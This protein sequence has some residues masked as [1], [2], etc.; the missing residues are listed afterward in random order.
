MQSKSK[1]NSLSSNE[2]VK[3]NS[4]DLAYNSKTKMRDGAQKKDVFEEGVK[5]YSI[6]L[7]WVNKDKKLDQTFIHNAATKEKLYTA[8]LEP[9]V[10]WKKANPEADV[11]IWYDAKLYSPEA[12]VRTK[13]ALEESIKKP[14]NFFKSFFLKK[15][16]KKALEEKGESSEIKFKDINDIPIVK[17]NR[18][19]FNEKIPLYFRIDLLKLVICLHSLTIESKD[20]AIFADLETGNLRTDENQIVTGA[21]LNKE[22]L[23]DEKSMNDLKQYGIITNVKMKVI[24]ENQFLQVINNEYIVEALRVNVNVCL[25]VI[26]NTLNMDLYKN[27]AGNQ[28]S[29]MSDVYNVPFHSTIRDVTRYYQSVQI[30]GGIKVRADIVGKGSEN[31]WVKYDP[32]D[33]GYNILGVLPVCAGG[34]LLFLDFSANLD[35]TKNI[36]LEV[37]KK[38]ISYPISPSKLNDCAIRETYTR[39]GNEH[40]DEVTLPE[41]GHKP[42]VAKF[43]KNNIEALKSIGYKPEKDELSEDEIF[44]AK[45]S[46]DFST[47]RFDD[48]RTVEKAKKLHSDIKKIVKLPTKD[49][50]FIRNNFTKLV[51]KRQDPSLNIDSKE[52]LEAIQKKLE[53]N[54]ENQKIDYIPKKEVSPGSGDVPYN[55]PKAQEMQVLGYIPC[56]VI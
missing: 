11:N 43:W 19:L 3:S 18:D 45:V 29:Y 6:N 31:E 50:D 37:V 13:K 23:F 54:E 27:L 52:L 1:F 35:S 14:S 46:E 55:E 44:L 40:K 9:A 30:P 26:A 12:V 21:R 41:K 49:Q 5:D 42:F 16:N 2:F 25:N 51:T 53:Q 7:L 39:Y 4:Q 32:Q 15:S 33:Y 38:I 47:I 17:L 8:F 28:K 22:E 20:S 34:D 36:K 10:K 48:I 24:A 56:D